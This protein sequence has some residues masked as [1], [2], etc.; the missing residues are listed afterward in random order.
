MVSNFNFFD[1]ERKE[2]MGHNYFL[3]IKTKGMKEK[4]CRVRVR[5]HNHL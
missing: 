2:S 5:R 3:D 1:N 4:M